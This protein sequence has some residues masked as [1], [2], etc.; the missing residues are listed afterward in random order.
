MTEYES[1]KKPQ[2]GEIE[3]T[4]AMELAGEEALL[5]SAICEYV[6]DEWPLAQLIARDV[7]LTMAREKIAPRRFVSKDQKPL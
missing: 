7:Y 3:I 5:N 1:D 4:P 2:N 6:G